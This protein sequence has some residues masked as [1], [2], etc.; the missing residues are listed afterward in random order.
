MLVENGVFGSFLHQYPSL[1]A[2]NRDWDEYTSDEQVTGQSTI[3][4][5]DIPVLTLTLRVL[6]QIT[7]RMFSSLQ[8]RDHLN[9]SKSV[10]S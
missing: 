3:P 10:C 8:I 9:V 6:D 2:M 4:H 5:S 1:N 7:V